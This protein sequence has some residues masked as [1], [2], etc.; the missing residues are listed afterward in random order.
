MLQVQFC[1]QDYDLS[2]LISRIHL[3]R[4]AQVLT[5]NSANAFLDPDR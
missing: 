5:P 3:P 4:L 1:G 2:W